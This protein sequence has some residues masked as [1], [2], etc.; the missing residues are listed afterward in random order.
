[1]CSSDLARAALAG[2][3]G[4]QQLRAAMLLAKVLK[5]QKRMIEAT[6]VLEEALQAVPE[7]PTGVEVRTHRYR[8]QA[9]EL[10]T[11]LKKP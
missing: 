5:A 11:E 3:Y 7:P 2:A 8:Q 1:M 10:L 6:K 9:Q 4:D